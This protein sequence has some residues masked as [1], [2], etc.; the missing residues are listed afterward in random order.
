MSKHFLCFG[1]WNNGLCNKEDSQNPISNVMRKLHENVDENTEFISILGDNYYAESMEKKDSDK[2]KKKLIDMVKL[3][4]GFDCLP[5]EKPIYM[6]LGNH[7]LDTSGEDKKFFIGDDNKPESGCYTIQ[8]EK[9]ALNDNISYVLHKSFL[10]GNCLVIMMD[11][12]MY[13]DE[14]DVEP[15][16]ECYAK[17]LN[18]ESIT[19]NELRQMQENFILES[20]ET[21]NGKYENIIWMGHHPIAGV[22]Q[23]EKSGRKKQK[24]FE[25]FTPLIQTLVGIH[26]KIA[27]N[28]KKPRQYY[29]CADIHLFQSGVIN[30]YN[31]KGDSPIQID[32]YISGTGGASLDDA[33]MGGFEFK[34]DDNTKVTY[35]STKIICKNGFIRCTI[36]DNVPR[37]EFIETDIVGGVKTRKNHR[38][39]LRRARKSRKYRKSSRRN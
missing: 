4:S 23:K 8:T 38:R 6:I 14:I 17:F 1:C 15:S 7:D 36:V 37:F 30:I 25:G 16:L 2:I 31:D 22:K 33:E 10:F 34:P 12:T 26:K 13:N 21:H 3:K 39:K 27:E 29:V 11:T 20:L 24:N 19:V 9:S 32:Q 28:E 18:R 5:K 35:N